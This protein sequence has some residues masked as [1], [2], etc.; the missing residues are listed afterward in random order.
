[1]GRVSCWAIHDGL[2]RDYWVT[3]T[4]DSRSK[5]TLKYNPG[6]EHL[7]QARCCSEA[8]SFYFTWV[9]VSDATG[10]CAP[11]WPQTLADGSGVGASSVRII[12]RESSWYVWFAL[13]MAEILHRYYNVAKFPF[14]LMWLER[15]SI[16]Q[17]SSPMHYSSFS[18]HS[19]FAYTT[20]MSESIFKYGDTPYSNDRRWTNTRL[21]CGCVGIRK[22]H[23]QS[24]IQ[25]PTK[26]IVE[27]GYYSHFFHISSV[28]EHK[29]C[30]RQ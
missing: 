2:P 30:M 1:M 12:A 4:W 13:T 27:R 20:I 14:M 15:G 16:S 3:S 11:G 5:L 21:R 24:L 23:S 28:L 18:H 7:L 9:R 10:I 17:L 29:T 6:V 26:A 25:V 19:F 22:S 8:Q